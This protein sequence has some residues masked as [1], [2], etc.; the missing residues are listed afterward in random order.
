MNN[1]GNRLGFALVFTVFAVV[2][3]IY[4]VLNGSAETFYERVTDLLL[5]DDNHTAE[6]D[7]QQDYQLLND[8]C[9][10][11]AEMHGGAARSTSVSHTRCNSNGAIGI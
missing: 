11:L 9:S 5:N 7:L 3:N 10:Q 2:L 4:V 6:A 1:T 8:G